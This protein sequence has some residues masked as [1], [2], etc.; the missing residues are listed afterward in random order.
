MLMSTTIVWLFCE[1]LL[2][3]FD[4]NCFSAFIVDSG[5]CYTNGMRTFVC[6]YWFLGKYRRQE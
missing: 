2:L 1:S 4:G 6:C 3:I 5:K